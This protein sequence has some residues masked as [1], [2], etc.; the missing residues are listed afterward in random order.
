MAEPER[1]NTY[2][3]ARM[4]RDLNYGMYIEGTGEMYFNEDSYKFVRP[5]Y[6]PFDKEIAYKVVADLAERRNFWESKRKEVVR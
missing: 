3:E 6:Q 4:I 5:E 1:L 2:F